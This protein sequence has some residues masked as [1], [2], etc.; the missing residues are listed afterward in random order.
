MAFSLPDV[1]PITESGEKVNFSWLQWFSQVSSVVN[2]AQQSGSTAGR[3]TKLL[4]I[5]RRYYDTDLGKP[6]FVRSVRPVVWRDAN[7]AI[8]TTFTHD[9]ASLAIG[10]TRVD[11]IAIAGAALGDYVQVAAP[12]SLQGLQ[13]TAY[14]AAADGVALLFVNNTGA[15]V[16]LAS[17]TWK[18]RLS[19]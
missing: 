19:K 4:W 10:A 14:V 1:S 7:N 17:G 12:Y 11:T 2:A 8:D 15:A 16:D 9:P 3:P 6:V 18:V 5:G 13:L